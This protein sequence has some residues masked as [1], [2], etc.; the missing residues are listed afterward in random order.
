MYLW[1]LYPLVGLAIGVALIEIRVLAVDNRL[2][3]LLLVWLWPLTLPFFIWHGL[4]VLRW[5]RRD[6]GRIDG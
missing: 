5:K 3:V 4:S 1:A 2:S 6:D